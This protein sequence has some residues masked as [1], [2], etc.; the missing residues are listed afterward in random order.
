MSLV[1]LKSGDL[2]VGVPLPW[3]VFG[4]NGAMLLNAGGIIPMED[5]PALLSAGLYRAQDE[6]SQPQA[7]GLAQR[8]AGAKPELPGLAIQVES[9]Q[10][11]MLEDGNKER[12]LFRVEFIG[13]IP[14]VSLILSQPQREGRLVPVPVGQ[15]LHVNLFASRFVHTFSGQI[16]C[17]Q[18]LPAPYM[19]LSHPDSIKTT[20]LRSAK[21]V[22]LQLGILALLRRG[23]EL[24]I[25]VSVIELSSKGLALLS[26]YPLGEPGASVQISFSVATGKLPQAIRTTGII[27][28]GRPL[29]SQQAYRYGLELTELTPEQQVAIQAFIYQNL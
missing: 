13:R 16:L 17:V 20:V 4:K 28:S 27:R 26:E 15:N 21:R 5:A 7:A 19:H 3:S 1:R 23:E 14:D 2:P 9:V 6:S 18:R 12:S 25:P 24:S 8:R 10:V 22:N 29:K 11:A